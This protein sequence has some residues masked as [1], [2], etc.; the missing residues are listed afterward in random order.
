VVIP[1]LQS[2]F[3]STIVAFVRRALFVLVQH[4]LL[5]SWL[6][7]IKASMKPYGKPEHEKRGRSFS[8]C[9]ANDKGLKELTL[10]LCERWDYVERAILV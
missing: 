9:M 4:A 1:K 3:D 10:K 2:A 7:V 6:C 5:A 8:R